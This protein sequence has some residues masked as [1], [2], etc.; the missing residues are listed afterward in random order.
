MAMEESPSI[1]QLPPPPSRSP[2]SAPFQPDGVAPVVWPAR[3]ALVEARNEI[4]DRLHIRVVGVGVKAGNHRGQVLLE[5]PAAGRQEGAIAAPADRTRQPRQLRKVGI[6]HGRADG[7]GAVDA[8]AIDRQGVI[9]R[10]GARD[11]AEIWN[12]D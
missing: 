9:L 11:P 5:R 4:A 10:K 2:A 12:D 7:A 6:E 3:A 1:W 8:D